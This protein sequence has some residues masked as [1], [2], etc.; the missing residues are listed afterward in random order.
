MLLLR[1]RCGLRVGA[2]RA[3]TWPTIK[4]TAGSLRS[5]NRTGPG[6]RGV[7]PAPDVAQG[8]RPW[9]RWPPPEAP[10]VVPRPLT[11]GLPLSGRAIQPLRA[12][13]LT[14]ARLTTPSSPHARR[15]TFAPQRLKAGAP[16]EGVT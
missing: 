3:C 6:D 13:D 8:R 12:K 5:D 2:V 1:R 10:D 4:L 9:R 14:V 16:W 15:Q 7:S 11:H